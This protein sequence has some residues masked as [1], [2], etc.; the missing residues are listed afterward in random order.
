MTRRDP[1]TPV[2]R[3]L[4]DRRWLRIG[5]LLVLAAVP[6]AVYAGAVPLL[7]QFVNG[8]IADADEVNANFAAVSTAVDDNDSRLGVLEGLPNQSCLPG[9]AVTGIDPGGA[10]LCVSLTPVPDSVVAVVIPTLWDSTINVFCPLEA[11]SIVAGGIRPGGGAGLCALDGLGV[12]V[13]HW[14]FSNFLGGGA[15]EPVVDLGGIF[16]TSCECFAVCQ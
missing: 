9:Q 10:L 1:E 2:L 7:V 15:C 3:R 8:Q 4:A 14:R 16:A 13:P 5:L 12:V 6:V 11:P